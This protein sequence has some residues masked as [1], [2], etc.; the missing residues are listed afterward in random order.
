MFSRT[1]NLRHGGTYWVDSAEVPIFR[2]VDRCFLAYYIYYRASI[3]R[4]KNFVM[5]VT[6]VLTSHCCTSDAGPSFKP[7]TGPFNPSLKS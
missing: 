3:R 1:K 6:A 7:V 4:H 2:L 5:R